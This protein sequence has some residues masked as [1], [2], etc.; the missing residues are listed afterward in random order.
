MPVKTSIAATGAIFVLHA[1]METKTDNSRC[2]IPTTEPFEK[3]CLDWE[4][5]S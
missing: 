5:R 3:L 4:M 2:S 1:I